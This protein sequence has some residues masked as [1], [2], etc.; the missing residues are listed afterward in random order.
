M[1]VLFQLTFSDV[2]LNLILQLLTLLY[3]VT[4]FH[5]K[6]AIPGF[7]NIKTLSHRI[8]LSKIRLVCNCIQDLLSI[9]CQGGICQTFCEWAGLTFL[10]YDSI[11]FSRMAECHGQAPLFSDHNVV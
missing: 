4:I 6:E 9:G 2:I 11:C 5:M 1:N 7:V 3:G 8:G 10:I